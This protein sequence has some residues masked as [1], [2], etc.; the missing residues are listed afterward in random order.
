[1]T[2]HQTEYYSMFGAF[3]LREGIELSAFKQ[4]YDTFCE[5]LNQQGYVH[6]WRLWKRAYHS[7]YDAQ[8]PD[9]G[10]MVEMCF[11][12]HAASLASW[13]YV[14]ADEEPMRSLHV[15][16]NTKVIDAFFVLFEEVA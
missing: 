3:N 5:H 12:D 15:A 9:V 8:F 11:H 4:V 13:G 6:S 2:K 10:V 7:G 14:K 16:V 1:M